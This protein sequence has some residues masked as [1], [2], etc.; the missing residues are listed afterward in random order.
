MEDFE[1]FKVFS[2]T[3]RSQADTLKKMEG[4]SSSALPWQHF[5]MLVWFSENRKAIFE[6]ARENDRVDEY[7]A[8]LEEF[9]E[10][11]QYAYSE[12]D[13]N[14]HRSE[15]SEGPYPDDIQEMY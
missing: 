10:L 13:E 7:N 4:K 11:K 8:F 14:N 5:K 1:L 12:E 2:Q 3:Y 9:P 6:S 15:E